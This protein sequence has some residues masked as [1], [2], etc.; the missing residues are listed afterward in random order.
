[1]NRTRAD[2]R[3]HGLTWMIVF[4][5]REN[6]LEQEALPRDILDSARYTYTPMQYILNSAVKSL[7]LHIIFVNRFYSFVLYVVFNITFS[8][9]STLAAKIF[10]SLIL[11]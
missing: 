11:L 2:N 10:L 8:G 4:R 1:M 3:K 9:L 7:C 6:C 5:P